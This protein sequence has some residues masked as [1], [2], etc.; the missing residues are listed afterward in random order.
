MLGISCLHGDSLFGSFSPCLCS[1]TALCFT[2]AWYCSI[3]TGGL[4][5]LLL[6]QVINI[7]HNITER[8]ARIALRNKTA[9]SAYWGLV[10]DTGVY[11]HGFHS[12]WAEFMTMGDKVNLPSPAPTDLV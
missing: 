6:V 3:V 10:V 5:H 11:S 7:S 2:C 1:S 9:R 4:L 8:E 12:N